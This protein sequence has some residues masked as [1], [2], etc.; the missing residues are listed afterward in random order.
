MWNIA[1]L[2]ILC[3]VG[4]GSVWKET[5][6]HF[7]SDILDAIFV[8]ISCLQY[9]QIRNCCV[10]NIS[11]VY[12]MGV[13]T[14]KFS[15][16]KKKIQPIRVAARSKARNVFARLKTEIVDS[17]C[18][19][20]MSVC[21]RLFCVGSG[22]AKGWSS[23]QGVLPAVYEI[24]NFIINS[25]WEQT[26][27]PSPS[28]RTVRYRAHQTIQQLQ[29]LTFVKSQYGQLHASKKIN[30]CYN[31]A[32]GLLAKA[33]NSM[34]PWGKCCYSNL[35]AG[36]SSHVCTYFAYVFMVYLTTL[37]VAQTTY[38]GGVAGVTNNEL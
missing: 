10:P 1:S 18:I 5:S 23:I 31:M 11:K 9:P 13:G 14:Y 7:L 6:T 3:D 19:W 4:I 33:Y 28:K 15:F 26:R 17:N 29:F 34:R 35:P 16:H 2:C 38:H 37:S 21:L 36:M 20:G 24:H 8:F 32:E 22:F 12:V 27:E 30:S 25:E